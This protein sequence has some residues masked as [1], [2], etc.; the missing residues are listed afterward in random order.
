MSEK[1]ERFPIGLRVWIDLP[2]DSNHMEGATVKGH[3]RDGSLVRVLVDGR[4]G[5]T[6]YSGVHLRVAS[7]DKAERARAW[8]LVRALLGLF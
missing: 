5:V 3:S 4:R 1:K 2:R 7:E 6:S 8:A